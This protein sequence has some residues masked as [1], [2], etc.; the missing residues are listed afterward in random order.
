[1][2]AE[3]AAPPAVVGAKRAA[4]ESEDGDSKRVKTEEVRSFQED[5]PL[6][7]QAKKASTDQLQHMLRTMLDKAPDHTKLL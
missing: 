3:D 7:Q 2:K 5:D 4:E 1:M 6:Y